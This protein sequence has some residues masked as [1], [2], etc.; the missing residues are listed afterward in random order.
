MG[1]P[2]YNQPSYKS[3]FLNEIKDA[4]RVRHYSI[5]TEQA[6]ISWVKRYIRY[7]GWQHP[8]DLS[9]VHVAD[10]LTHLATQKRVN[11]STQNQAIINGCPI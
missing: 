6:Y 5:R 3:P 10:F 4:I 2:I 1:T 11:A 8:K 7:H 9:E